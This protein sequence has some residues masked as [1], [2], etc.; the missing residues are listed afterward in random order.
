MRRI[1]PEGRHRFRDRRSGQNGQDLGLRTHKAVLNFDQ[2]EGGRNGHCVSAK[3][4]D[5]DRQQP[6]RT[7]LL[8]NV[9][10]N[11]AK[12]EYTGNRARVQDA[13]PGGVNAMQFPTTVNGS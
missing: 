6:G 4:L 9:N 10:F 8:W 3:R 11:A 5:C 13:H 1:L 2:S 12:H 7:H